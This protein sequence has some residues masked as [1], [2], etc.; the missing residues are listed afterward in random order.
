[1]SQAGGGGP[2]TSLVG[3]P[4]GMPPIV[5]AIANA[6]RRHTIA[7]RAQFFLTWAVIV[8]GVIGLVAIAS[9]P[10]PRFHLE[11]WLPFILG[12]IG[13]TLF[14]S[15]TS[16]VGAVFLAIFGALGRLSANPVL[17]G[18]AS[19]YVSLVRGTPL[20][21]QIFF[22]YLGL[23]A[24]GIVVP[25]VPT[26]IIALSFNYGAYLTEVF[27]AGIQAVPQGQV[28]AARSLGLPER[29]VLRRIVLPQAI[30]IVTPAVANDFIAMTKD[31]ALISV[32]GVQE[33]LWRA[34]AA[35]RPNGTTFQTIAVAAAIYWVMTIVLSLFQA[36]LER[37][38]AAGDRNR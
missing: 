25:E 38:M 33:L 23:P 2:A 34:Q 16:I 6:E 31:S 3:S 1:V 21:V 36:R 30:R 17:N 11:E 5:V 19:L 13:M 37:R 9:H 28:E 20:I 4:P 7:F 15:I 14:L 10:N 29:Q 22:I 26:G 12:G 32:I 8:A 27:R 18:V 35:G 24:V